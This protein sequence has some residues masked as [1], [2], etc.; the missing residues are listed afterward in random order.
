M[1][2]DEDMRA[3]KAAALEKQN[4]EGYRYM[5]EMNPLKHMLP[6]VVAAEQRAACK[7]RQEGNR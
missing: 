2:E 5:G 1:R 3:G 4:A 7:V 6:D